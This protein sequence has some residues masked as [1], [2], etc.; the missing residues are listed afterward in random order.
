MT[1]TESTKSNKDSEVT[2]FFRLFMKYPIV[3]S[4]ITLLL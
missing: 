3:R 1:A 4:I 2:Y